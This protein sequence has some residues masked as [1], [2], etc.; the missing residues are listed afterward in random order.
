MKELGPHKDS[1][2]KLRTNTMSPKDIPIRI[3]YK[4]YKCL[5]IRGGEVPTSRR[6]DDETAEGMQDSRKELD[7]SAV[8]QDESRV[9][10]ALRCSHTV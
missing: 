10:L 8:S 9:L 3:T 6:A 2:Y 7:R 5:L 4:I 1:K